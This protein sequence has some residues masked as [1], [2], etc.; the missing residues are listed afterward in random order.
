MPLTP[1]EIHAQHVVMVEQ[2]VLMSHARVS[3]IEMEHS[4]QRYKLYCLGDV[5]TYPGFRRKGYGAKVVAAATDLIRQDA[6]ADAAILF[7]DPELGGFYG[8][9]GWEHIPGF[10]Y[11]LGNPAE[12]V[13]YNAF[14]MMLFFSPQA[15]QHRADFATQTVYLPGYAW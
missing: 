4:G 1:S 8:Q 6:T 13:N 5:L 3:W 15:K 12:P 7:T 14:A 9:S 10:S 2:H 11:I